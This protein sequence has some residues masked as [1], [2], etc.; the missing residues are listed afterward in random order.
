MAFGKVAAVP[1]ELRQHMSAETGQVLGHVRGALV[2][3]LLRRELRHIM[4]PTYWV[5]EDCLGHALA[6][7]HPW[8]RDVGL[9]THTIQEAISAEGHLQRRQPRPGQLAQQRRQPRPGQ[10]P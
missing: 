6:Q 2:S 1:S 5:R 9:A 3:E 4:S 7:Q 10:L 8:L